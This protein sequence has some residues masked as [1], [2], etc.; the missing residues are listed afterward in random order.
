MGQEYTYT[1]NLYLYIDFK[2]ILNNLHYM[3]YMNSN[4]PSGRI[5][6]DFTPVVIGMAVFTGMF[7]AI[8]K[9]FFRDKL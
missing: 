5:K 6:P 9:Y 3:N 4:K 2:S 8:Q 7:L 1:I